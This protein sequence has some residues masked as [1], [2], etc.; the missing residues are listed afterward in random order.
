[1]KTSKYIHKVLI[2]TLVVF[3][4]SCNDFLDEV[5]QSNFTLE[6]YFTRP[7]HA[8]SVVNSIYESLRPTMQSG[9]NGGPW[10]MLEFATGLA[11]TELGQAQNSLFVRSLINN[12]DNAYGQTY[13]TSY[14]RGI[15]NA[16]LAI[17]KIPEIEMDAAAQ[18]RLLGEARFLRAYYY[19]GLIRIF[20]NIPLITEP[21]D[22][23]S[24]EMY[25]DPATA[26]QVY[27]QIVEDL[28]IAEDSGLPYKET[29]GRVSLG[30]VKSMLSSVYL[31]MAGYPLQKGQ[32]YYQLAA[33]K[34]QEVIQS[35]E[36]SLF[37]SY[38][39]LHNVEDKNQGEH[40]FMAQYAAFIMPS[41]WQ[42]SIIP[43]NRGISAYNDETGGI[44]ANANFV[45]SFEE[46]DKRAEE[47]EFFY[48]EYSLSSNRNTILPLGDYYLYKHFD[49]EAQLSTTS[50]GL[51]WM[52][53]RYAEVLLTYAE[54]ANEA[55]GPTT[56]AYE[57]VN[58]IRRR[59][60]LPDLE[61]LSQQEL[62]EA[63][64]KERWVE[65]CYENKTW[66]DMVRL[67]KAYNTLEGRFEDFVG[68]QFSYGPTLRERELLFPIPTAEIR[69]N[70]KLTQNQGY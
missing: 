45:R 66:Y 44:F 4:W 62:R 54:A 25:P 9:F 43:Y 60:E 7:E 37:S 31:T 38:E 57:A 5:D 3:G 32:E 8:T 17:A 23:S 40:I 27:N 55:F 10:M 6:N 63:I 18:S 59:A 53:Y 67:R 49:E 26:E 41:S 13:W 11:D 1:M 35:G 50:S 16:N 64:W 48:T 21:I 36:F 51:N 68:H 24:P 33:E 22:L 20:G 12:S 70:G 61:G 14:Y 30:A 34:A 52:I 2:L 39:S 47:K 29:T 19:F 56:E 65:L 69:N 28:T 15:A 42:V 46:G 58:Q